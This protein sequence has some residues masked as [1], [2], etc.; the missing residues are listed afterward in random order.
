MADEDGNIY[1][2]L[3]QISFLVPS[4]D[5]QGNEQAI[6]VEAGSTDD[7]PPE[8]MDV[9]SVGDLRIAGPAL[10][11]LEV[12]AN[13]QEPMSWEDWYQVCAQSFCAGFASRA[14]LQISAFPPIHS[15]GCIDFARGCGSKDF[16]L[17]SAR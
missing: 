13:N 10:P 7:I 16:D 17:I 1:S 11:D 2:E 4:E 3:E 5:D 12:L 6:L 15:P 9:G 8:L 14:Y